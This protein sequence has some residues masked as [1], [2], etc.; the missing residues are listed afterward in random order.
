M[1][2]TVSRPVKILALVL[3]I[4]G[5][6]GIAS[7]S[8]LG[9]SSDAGSGNAQLSVAQIRA[10]AHHTATTAAPAT[11]TAEPAKGNEPVKAASNV[12]PADRPVADKLRDLLGAKSSRYFDRKPE[13]TAVGT[14]LTAASVC[15]FPILA[16][17]KLRLAAPLG[18]RALRGDGVLSLAGAVLAGATLA[19]LILDSIAAEQ[20]EIIYEHWREVIDLCCNRDDVRLG[21]VK[22]PIAQHLLFELIERSKLDV[23]T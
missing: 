19:S 18:S 23:E 20:Y 12:A 7:L 16:R 1:D 11:P 4:A 14:A 17:A 3:V 6:G 15:V 10:R 2:L 13:R 8:M 5:V 9:K 21:R 22:R